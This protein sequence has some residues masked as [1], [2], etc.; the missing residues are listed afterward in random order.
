MVEK[1]WKKLKQWIGTSSEYK[2]IKDWNLDQF[3]NA[4]IGDIIDNLTKDALA[5]K[6][7]IPDADNAQRTVQDQQTE[8]GI[9]YSLLS[10]SDFNK[11]G[12][13]KES[14]LKEIAE[15]RAKIESEA[16]AN[17][18]WM[19]APNGE[20]TNL[21]EQQ[22]V[23]VRTKR[24]KEW[25]GDWELAGKAEHI[26][27]GKPVSELTG[28]EFAKS[29][30]SILDQVGD[31]FKSIG[32]KVDVKG[33]GQVVL[34]R[35]SVK[36]S[37]S[38][39]IGRSKASAFKAIPE[40][41][42]KGQIVNRQTNWKDRGYGSYTISAPITINGER[43]VAFAI[44]N[45]ATEQGNHRFY[46]HEVVLQKSLQS[47][48]FKTGMVT[49]SPQGDIAKIVRNI[50]TAQDNTS[51]VVDENGEPLVVYHGTSGVFNEFKPFFRS[52][53]QQGYF[54][55]NSKSE[56]EKWGQNVIAAF[57]NITNPL[58]VDYG[59]EM[60][61]A[62]KVDNLFKQ[63]QYEDGIIIENI[64][65][66]IVLANQ[67]VALS[68][69]QIKS[70]T[71]NVGTYSEQSND[72]RFS[73]TSKPQ[74]FSSDEGKSIKQ[75]MAGKPIPVKIAK[76]MI[77]LMKEV[78]E[79]TNTSTTIFNAGIEFLKE[80]EWYQNLSTEDKAKVETP[81]FR[82]AI[83]Q[84][85]KGLVDADRKIE[86]I[87]SKI[88]EN[89]QSKKDA[90]KTLNDFIKSSE[91]P[92][93]FVTENEYKYLMRKAAEVATHE[94]MDK[95]LNNFHE[96]FSKVSMRAKSREMASDQPHKDSIKRKVLLK[97]EEMLSKGM[98][99]DDIL[100][101]FTEDFEKEIARER[102]NIYEAS[103]RERI[104]RPKKKSLKARVLTKAK[105]WQKEWFTNQG[106]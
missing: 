94:D 54:F 33:I 67:Y 70:A 53:N 7:V 22:W 102:L 66:R 30:K 15:E 18:T 42:T 2:N 11:D 48:E 31:F 60:Y 23:D 76:E 65:D 55:F 59:K 78:A 8:L 51:K 96:A 4:T 13:V 95:A 20:K 87:K 32:G 98:A 38:H 86:A 81:V 73:I 45:E 103:K 74:L 82:N 39:G 71:D 100:N 69:N 9:Q 77:S 97:V 80:S 79:F 17:G 72:I 63:L 35:R 1:F 19:K 46:L 14:V 52:P 85:V 93:E 89:K 99:F 21:N 105:D 5:G 90:V 3:K 24:F 49:G 27:N 41:L 88:K 104:N 10:E 26:L 58:N 62:E 56:A 29:D 61:Q 25:F 91:L 37:L 92:K 68:P 40:I 34:D 47:E 57:L 16:K 6:E 12:T 106:I 83:G 28:K 84:M 50:V 43:F 36:D 44:V 75:L 101:S 64:K